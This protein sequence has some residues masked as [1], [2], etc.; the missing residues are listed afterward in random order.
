MIVNNCGDMSFVAGRFDER[1]QPFLDAVNAPTTSR[2]DARHAL[3]IARIGIARAAS[4]KRA[5]IS[6]WRARVMQI[7]ASS[8]ALA[9]RR[10]RT[11]RVRECIGFSSSCRRLKCSDKTA[12]RCRVIVGKWWRRR[13]LRSRPE[14]GAVAART[15]S[16]MRRQSDVGGS[17][18]IGNGYFRKSAAPEQQFLE[19]FEEKIVL[20]GSPGGSAW[21]DRMVPGRARPRSMR[22]ETKL[23]H[24]RVRTISGGG[25]AHHPPSRRQSEVPHDLP[26]MISAGACDIRQIVV[27]RDQ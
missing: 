22:R 18:H 15:S 26:I 5:A 4:A 1:E 25:S 12:W 2:A 16:Q 13:A 10:C 24:L 7:G 3:A 11:R 17:V 21:I 6:P 27:L 20:G 19:A 23:Q 8:D 14:L 9:R